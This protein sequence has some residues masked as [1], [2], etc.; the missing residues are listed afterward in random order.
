LAESIIGDEAGLEAIDR[1]IK[2]GLDLE[3]PFVANTM[4][5]QWEMVHVE[6]PFGVE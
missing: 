1:A 5:T 4:S 6:S 3:N 2:I